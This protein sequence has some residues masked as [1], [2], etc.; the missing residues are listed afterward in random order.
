MERVSILK[1]LNNTQAEKTKDLLKF[2]KYIY[3]CNDCG[4]VYGSD[5]LE[6]Y[7]RCPNCKAKL[8]KENKEKNG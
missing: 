4:N 1:L 2:Y 3:I 8:T 5:M 6:K 7:Q